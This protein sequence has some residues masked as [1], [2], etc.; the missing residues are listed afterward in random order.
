MPFHL[1]KHKPVAGPTRRAVFTLKLRLQ[2]AALGGFV[3]LLVKFRFSRG[4]LSV[5]NVYAM[6][7][8]S[9]SVVAMG[10]TLV[11]F[12]VVPVGWL[13]RI[14]EWL[15]SGHERGKAPR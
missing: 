12:A 11:L 13:E 15:M 4:V 8:D 3:V 5:V 6:D 10:A 9:W 2:V 14:A 1:G 7:V